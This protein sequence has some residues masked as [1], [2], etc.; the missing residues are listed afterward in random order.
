MAVTG[1]RT[2]RC[3]LA[4]PRGAQARALCHGGR[5]PL[6]PLVLPPVGDRPGRG[7][8]AASGQVVPR[9]GELLGAGEV[10]GAGTVP[11]GEVARRRPQPA[12]VARTRRPRGEAGMA[13][14][15]YAIATLA[16]CGFAG[17]L[18]ALLAS[19]QVRGLL[20]GI[21]SRALSVG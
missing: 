8:G 21:I 13:T 11:T 17:L 19:D 3:T 15:E 1:T 16:A 5:G 2:S 4:R 10:L 18:L 12:R 7:A 9:A 20:L 14:A 6:S